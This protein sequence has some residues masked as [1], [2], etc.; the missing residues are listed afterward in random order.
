VPWETAVAELD[1]VFA[2][3]YS[4]SVFT[5]WSGPAQVWVKSLDEV[6]LPFTPAEGP[7]HMLA[8]ESV[9]AVTEQG[10]VPGP[11]LDRLPHFR[12]GHKPSAGEELQSEYLVPR[13]RAAEAIRRLRA[14]SGRIAPLLQISEIRSVA[15]DDLWL[16]GAYGHDTVGLHFTW[17]LDPAGVGALLPELEAALL[18]LGARPHWGKCFAATA[19][20]LAPLYPRWT[21]FAELRR[22]RDPRGKFANAFTARVF[23]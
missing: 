21:E 19:P 7:I 10:G 12:L 18:P 9:A 13:E 14:M 6:S 5:D 17:R 22:S 1:T 8:G 15:A 23:G 16:S 4:V 2:S 3:G 11:W 20:E